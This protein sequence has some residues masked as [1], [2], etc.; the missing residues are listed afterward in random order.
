VAKLTLRFVHAFTD[1][2]GRLRHYVRRPGF[3]AVPL[4]G[5]VGST[6]FMAAYAVALEAVKPPIGSGNTVPGSLTALVAAWR[7]SGEFRGLSPVSQ[8]N[9][10]RILDRLLKQFGN[11]PAARLEA[12]HIRGW[13][14][15]HADR[16]NAGN[17][18]LSIL[19]Q[20]LRFGVERG[21]VRSNAATDVR[22]LKIPR[23]GHATWSDADIAQFEAVHP[24]GSRARLA[25]RILLYTAA[26]RSDAIRLGWHSVRNGVI[27]F[28][29]NKTGDDVVIPVHPDLA[30]EIDR[31]PTDA[32]AW[33]M[34]EFGKTFASGAAFGNWFADCVRKAGLSDR[35]AHGLRKANARSLAE[36][37]ATAREIMAVTGHRTMAEAERYSA[38][39]DRQKMA[40]TAMAKMQTGSAATRKP[41]EIPS[42]INALPPGMASRRGFEPLLAP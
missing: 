4:P 3:K 30:E 13:L 9:V 16:P 7:G 11:L 41:G 34:T 15:A 38:A 35:S 14:D 19:R 31:L 6:E 1:R 42:N 21:L 2:H 20:V 36:H 18:L 12:K 39:A 17:K 24:A 28:R 33:L 37:G 23:G 5:D 26:R 22:R 27:D 32:A 40:V 29:Q 8:H 10:M 25:L